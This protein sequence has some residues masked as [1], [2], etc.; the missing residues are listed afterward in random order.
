MIN[1][2]NIKNFD[3]HLILGG[4]T[5]TGAYEPGDKGDNKKKQLSNWPIL[6]H[7][8]K[9]MIF[10]NTIPVK[11]GS[12][13]HSSFRGENYFCIMANQK[14]ELPVSAM[15]LSDQNKI[16]I[17]FCRGASKH[18]TCKVWFQLPCNFKA[19]DWNVKSLQ[20]MEAKWWQ[21]LTWSF[22]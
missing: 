20:M 7:C 15:F 14:E 9:M 13:W 19:E 17:F 2:R 18:H 1:K 3:I 22:E 4:E 10:Q 6:K 12:N 11:F 5:T 21:K 16:G 8:N